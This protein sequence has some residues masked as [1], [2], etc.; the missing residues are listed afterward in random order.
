MSIA[1]ELLN[2]ETFLREAYSKLE[3]KGAT[4]PEKKNLANLASTIENMSNVDFVEYIESTGTQYIDTGYKPNSNTK[5]EAELYAIKPANGSFLYGARNSGAEAQFGCY[6]NLGDEAQGRYGSQNLTAFANVGMP[7][8][9]NIV[10]DKNVI[11]LNDETITGNA[12]VF[13]TNYNM[14][15]LGMNT[16]G[17]TGSFCEAGTRIFSFKIYDN[18][19]LLRNFKPCIDPNGVY[20]LYDLVESRYYYNQGT[21][22]FLYG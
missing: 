7:K 1:Q 12:E 9:V 2:S 21:G 13:S 16:G 18:G 17:T 22:K 15:I 5:I 3:E 14:L 10:H 4:M 20:C 8:T 11:T 6:T 19:V